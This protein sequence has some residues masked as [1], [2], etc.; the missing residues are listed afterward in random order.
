M[1]DT[2]V[3]TDEFA[4]PPSLMDAKTI[5]Y[6]SGM[7]STLNGTNRGDDSARKYSPICRQK[8]VRSNG[9]SPFKF[10]DRDGAMSSDMFTSLGAFDTLDQAQATGSRKQ[11]YSTK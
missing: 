5:T 6:R 8:F 11:R 4:E 9:G 1:N 7:K 3:I 2:D 10:G